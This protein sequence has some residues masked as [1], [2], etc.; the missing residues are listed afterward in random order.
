MQSTR[1]RAT[2]PSI[3]V[4]NRNEKNGEDM[5]SV[6]NKINEYINN[7]KI[8]TPEFIVIAGDNY[9]PEKKKS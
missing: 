4:G 1:T 5:D 3:V 9:Y 2:V 6:M 7:D 8:L